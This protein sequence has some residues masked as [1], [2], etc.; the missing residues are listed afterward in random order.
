MSDISIPE[1]LNMKT[2]ME[3]TMSIFSDIIWPKALEQLAQAVT[4][5]NEINL[6]TAVYNFPKAERKALYQLISPNRNQLY[7]YKI[8]QPV[9]YYLFSFHR[10][11]SLFSGEETILPECY[12]ALGIWHEDLI[13]PPQDTWFKEGYSKTL[14][15]EAYLNKKYELF[16]LL[17]K[18]G[19]TVDDLVS[20]NIKDEGRVNPI[21]HFL[22]QCDRVGFFRASTNKQTLY[23][24]LTEVFAL[25]F[26]L[27]FKLDNISADLFIDYGELWVDYFSKC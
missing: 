3:K 7:G 20:N 6:A 26:Q 27:G 15:P 23:S 2:L 10:G 19:I 5:S 12:S 4:E 22:Q 21:N 9:H 1:S 25:L 14:V 16:R 18:A 8:V 24:E 17:M 13:Y 11:T